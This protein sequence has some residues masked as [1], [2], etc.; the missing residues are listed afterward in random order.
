MSKVPGP[1]IPL[2]L[3]GAKIEANYPV[4]VI[5]A[6]MGLHTTVMSYCGHLDFGLLADR[7]QM[8]DVRSLIGWL[9]EGLEDL[10]P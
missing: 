6:G 7:D 8:P 9:R 4:S 10:K 2:Y 5:T 1:K 3:A